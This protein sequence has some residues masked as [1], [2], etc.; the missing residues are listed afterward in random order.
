MFKRNKELKSEI[1]SLK[2]KISE[3]EENINMMATMLSPYKVGDTVEY[4]N[5]DYYT[6][7]ESSTSISV[8]D[9]IGIEYY[10]NTC[11]FKYYSRNGGYIASN[12]ILGKCEY[13]RVEK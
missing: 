7:N 5:I 8:I 11:V 12:L 3:L 4:S 10:G 2:E 9:Q 13:K 1:A 6:G